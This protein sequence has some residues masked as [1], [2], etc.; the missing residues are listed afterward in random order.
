VPVAS[1]P[2]FSAL[3]TLTFNAVSAFN[4]VSSYMSIVFAYT[5]NSTAYIKICGAYT[6]NV[7]TAKSIAT[8]CKVIV[9]HAFSFAETKLVNAI[10]TKLSDVAVDRWLGLSCTPTKAGRF[11][12]LLWYRD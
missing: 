5:S 11:K 6:N 3:A 7:N 10:A 1:N 2:I 8:P 9:G 4:D 12:F